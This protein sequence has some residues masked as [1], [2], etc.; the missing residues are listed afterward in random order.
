MEEWNQC[1]RFL[2]PARQYHYDSVINAA[3]KAPTSRISWIW[4]LEVGPSNLYFNKFWIL[5]TP[6]KKFLEWQA[7][8]KSEATHVGK[9]E[10]LIKALLLTFNK[11][12]SNKEETYKSMQAQFQDF[13]STGAKWPY[14]Y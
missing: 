8:D 6:A 13:N 2:G 9:T 1:C 14:W 7:L 4:D 12:D 3:E 5:D 11:P 10:I